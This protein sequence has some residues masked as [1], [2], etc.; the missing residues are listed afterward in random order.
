MNAARRYRP[1]E[2]RNSQRADDDALTTV[3]PGRRSASLTDVIHCLER[4]DTEAVPTPIPAPV[5]SPMSAP[6]APTVVGYGRRRRAAANVARP[7]RPPVAPAPAPAPAPA[8]AKN[9][10]VRQ[11]IELRSPLAALA[12]AVSAA[13]A[14][15]FL[16]GRFEI[17]AAGELLVP[18]LAASAFAAWFVFGLFRPARALPAILAAP[19]TFALLT[20]APVQPSPPLMIAAASLALVLGAALAAR[21]KRAR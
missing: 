1:D 18:I 8:R 14:T 7:S 12:L 3:H 11:G 20:S 15:W 13:F 10:P 17:P 6:P 5:R 4:A 2:P 9:E 16:T 21:S 19:L